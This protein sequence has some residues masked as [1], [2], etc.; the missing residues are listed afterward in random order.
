MADQGNLKSDDQENLIVLTGVTVLIGV[1]LLILEI[2]L[3][4]FEADTHGF[5]PPA[6]VSRFA[7]TPADYPSAAR[8]CRTHR[9]R[10]QAVPPDGCL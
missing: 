3:M 10:L 8:Q 6:V 9:T 4:I 7:I 5:N 1:T 2:L